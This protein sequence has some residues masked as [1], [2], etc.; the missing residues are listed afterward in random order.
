MSDSSFIHSTTDESFELDVFE[1]S[2]TVPVVV[3]FW[4]DWCQPCRMLA[5]LLEQRAEA[6]EGSWILV[7]ANTDQ[8]PM[9]ASQFNVQGIPAVYA[10]V[11]GEVVD[12]FNGVISETQL[13]G[14]LERVVQ[15]GE[16][17]Q[18]NELRRS[19]PQAASAR[20]REL[21][22]ESPNDAKLQVV[23]LESLYEANDLDACREQLA[24]MEKRGF[25]EPEAAKVKAEL[26]LASAADVDLDALRSA[27]EQA[28]NFQAKL[29]LGA[30][31]AGAHQFEESL[32]TLL[33]IVQDDRH[34][35]G[36]AAREKMV[37]VFQVLP[38]D[39]ELT[40][41][42]RRKLASALY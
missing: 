32:Q 7:K 12:F 17:L 21:L 30:A 2:K 18:L 42:Y 19:D 40:S 16:V 20:Y 15:Q 5:P 3:D 10:V 6:G 1:R 8:T 13:D 33:S 4:A 34:G 9:S 11:D 39:S 27:A 25:L 35:L 31:L 14:W 38:A 23:L 29:D 37:E 28:D 22:D 36:D 24:A 26:S 41:V